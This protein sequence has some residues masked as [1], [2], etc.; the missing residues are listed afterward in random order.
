[1]EAVVG[2]ETRHSRPYYLSLGESSHVM[3][4]RTKTP[5]NINQNLWNAEKELD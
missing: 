3:D 5:Q 2:P 1:M 4:L